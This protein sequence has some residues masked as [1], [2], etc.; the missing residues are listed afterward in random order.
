MN[1]FNKIVA[2]TLPYMPKKI[3]WIF[4]KRYVAGEKIEDGIAKSKMLN[5]QNMEVTVDLLGEFIHTLEEA[6]T[7]KNDYLNIIERFTEDN[8]KGS[9]S[10]KP[11][12]FGLLIDKEK[13]YRLI[14]E[15][16]ES[17]AKRNKFV[18]IDMEDSQCTSSEIELFKRLLAEFP[19]HVGLVLQAYLRRTRNDIIDLTAYSKQNGL[20]LNIRLCKGIYIEPEEIA[21]HDFHHVRHHFLKD[22]ELLLQNNAYVGIATHDPF[23]VNESYE[24]ITE[25]N[26]SPESYEFQMLYGVTPNLRDSIIQKGHIMRIYVPF[27]VDWFGYCS[28]RIK[29]NPKMVSDIIKALF[30]RG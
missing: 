3:V 15:V 6:E 10:V 18:R 21:Y 8:V 4:S 24:L 20:P 1:M 16:V 22:L 7:N 29:E 9:F 27:G 19:N 23:L 12:S 25:Y 14:R 13:C 11:T 26:K 5:S 30:I 28:R 17:A 2:D